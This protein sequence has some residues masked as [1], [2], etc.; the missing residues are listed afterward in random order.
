MEGGT[1]FHFVADGIH[2]ALARATAAANGKDS[3]LGG[4]LATIRQCLRESLIDEIHLAISP[5][6]LGSREHLFRDITTPP[7]PTPCTSFSPSSPNLSFSCT[8]TSAGK[9]TYEFHCA[10]ALSYLCLSVFICGHSFS[11]LNR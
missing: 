3:R 2:A 11:E 5:V 9:L 1:V 10:K 8:S 4:G 7:P 6:L